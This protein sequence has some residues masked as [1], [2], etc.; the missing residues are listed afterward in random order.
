VLA[1]PGAL[2]VAEDAGTGRGPQ[3]GESLD[4]QRVDEPVV[5]HVPGRDNL[6]EAVRAWFDVKV[7]VTFD[8]LQASRIAIALRSC[9]FVWAS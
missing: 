5:A 9:V 2:L 1:S 7:P 4:H 8:D 6:L 3:R